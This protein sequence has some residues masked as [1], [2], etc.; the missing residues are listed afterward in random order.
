MKFYLACSYLL[1]TFILF[2]QQTEMEPS[3]HVRHFTVENGLSNDWI[4]DIHQDERGYIWIGTQYGL[5]CFDGEKFTA[6]TYHPNQLT[7][8]NANWVKK[9]AQDNQGRFYLGTLGAGYNLFDHQSNQFKEIFQDSILTNSSVNDI[10]FTKAGD[11]W[12]ATVAG[13]FIIDQDQKELKKRFPT[14]AYCA[15]SGYDEESVLIGDKDGLK[16]Y[17]LVGDLE[18]HLLEGRTVSAIQV[19]SQDRI[20]LVS[21]R[22]LIELRQIPDGGWEEKILKTTVRESEQGLF[23]SFIYL[24]H[25]EQLWVQSQKGLFRCSKDFKEQI[26]FSPNQLLKAIDM[27]GLSIHVIFQDKERSYWIGT[28]QGLFQLI[29]T[30]PFLHPKLK[31]EGLSFPNTRAITS[32][33]QQYL[34][35]TTSG[36]F[37][38]DGVDT[39]LL[40][41]LPVISLFTANSGLSYGVFKKNQQ[42]QVFEINALTKAVKRIDSPVIDTTRTT[43][44]SIT[45]DANSRIWIAQW[46]HLVCYDPKNQLSFP[47]YFMDENGGQLRLRTI[48]LEID[49][50]DRLWIAT[51]SE[52]LIQV[53]NVSQLQK[54]TVENHQQYLHD[55]SDPTSLSSSLVQTV[56][57]AKDHTVWIGTDGGLNRFL[58]QSNSFQRWLRNEQMV[59][60]KI[61]GITEDGNGRLWLSTVGH[62]ILSFNPTTEQFNQYTRQDGLVDNAM[63]LSSVYQDEIGQIWM[64]SSKGLH[65]FFPNKIYNDSTSSIQLS[66][67]KLIRYQSD[68]TLMESFPQ[69]GDTQENPIKIYPKD[70]TIK[71]DFDLLSFLNTDQ[72]RFRFLLKGFHDDWLPEQNSGELLLSH[73]PQGQ[74]ILEA[75]GYSL[76][77]DLQANYPPIYIQVIPPW[78]NSKLAWFIYGCSF[79]LLVFAFYQLQLKRKLSKAEELRSKEMVANKMRWFHQIAHE[80][81]TPLTI[82][83]GAIDQFRSVNN[84]QKT[85]DKAIEQVETQAYYLNRQI[86]GILDLAKAQSKQPKL[87][88]QLGDFISYQRY[89]L[90][91][92]STL[93]EPQN[94]QLQFSSN[95]DK[96]FFYYDEEA[97]RKIS[98]NLISNALKFT[99]DGG[100]IKFEIELLQENQ[101]YFRIID[102]G[103]GIAPQLRDKIFEAFNQ[104][105]NT[106]RSGTGIGLALV[107][108]LVELQGGQIE[109]E[110]NTDNQSSF[111]I[112]QALKENEVSIQ[113]TKQPKEEPIQKAKTILIAEDH[114]EICNYLSFCLANQYQLAIKHNG[115]EA[116]TYCQNELPDLVISDIMMPGYSGLELSK[117]VRANSNTDH[118]PLILLTAKAGQQTRLEGLEAGADEF[119]TKPFH[120][121]ELLLKIERLLQVQQRLQ[122]K[123]SAGD[124]SIQT[125]T[126]RSDTFMQRVVEQIEKEL[127][128]ED[129]NVQRLADTLHL[130]RVHLF[131]KIKSLTGQNPTFLI[132]QVRLQIAKDRLSKT[133]HSIAEIAYQVGFKDPAYFSKVFLEQYG[134]RPSEMRN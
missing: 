69:N 130:S 129:F 5:N 102:S 17:N 22:Q 92:F 111:L 107:K 66:L 109:V 61:L 12:A 68:T 45:E 118:I 94:I 60:D 53:P 31:S 91:S 9:I 57:I 119:L 32:Y 40:I 75:K 42:Q 58:P 28:N 1:F 36:L 133:D 77:Q 70:N 54:T 19:V 73:L 79:L 15:V 30:K 76:N 88:L 2:G 86:D 80:F 101:L 82:I 14:Y 114:P 20:V 131:R 100:T 64:G 98:T 125:S 85:N 93:A 65:S 41:D 16:I 97:W 10:L 52:G 132:R 35:G 26:Y 43:S 87:A 115:N 49:Q 108:T 56:F 84:K 126:A 128:N 106:Q 120:R 47:V 37:H 7:G 39:S 117:L 29:P 123:Y 63:L 127:G 67:Q 122:E 105:D 110:R 96:L 50:N 27:P 23:G 24:D 55:F 46:N 33:Q 89:L 72:H 8:L 113:H 81:K 95:V 25:F 51:V 13:V 71:F 38:W 116:W 48:D 83:F 90:F 21:Q 121:Q 4:S 112:T 11:I 44:W 3:F 59:D 134:C 62:G 104:G 78:Y 74:Y 103:P 99:P 18:S 124:F 34:F 6:Y